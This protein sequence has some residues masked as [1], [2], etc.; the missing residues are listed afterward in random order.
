[1]KKETQVMI[2]KG[3]LVLLAALVPFSL[4]YLVGV[5]M[6]YQWDAGK[7]PYEG[8]AAVGLFGMVFGIVAGVLAGL[9]L[10]YPRWYKS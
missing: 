3:I 7:W 10:Y 6:N 2:G 5:F 9:G 8:R 1:M 4:L